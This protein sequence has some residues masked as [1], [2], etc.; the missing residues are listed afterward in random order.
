MYV[1]TS[2][3]FRIQLVHWGNVCVQDRHVDCAPLQGVNFL[4]ADWFKYR[5]N[6]QS[7][8]SYVWHSFAKSVLW[9]SIWDSV[10]LI[11]WDKFY[12]SLVVL[13]S[14]RIGYSQH[15][16]HSRAMLYCMHL[17]GAMH[18]SRD[19]N[20]VTTP[21]ATPHAFSDACRYV[22]LIRYSCNASFFAARPSR[23]PSSA[24]NHRRSHQRS[25]ESIGS[26]FVERT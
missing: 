7:C 8:V 3:R 26:G 12:T 11:L 21:P 24:G 4:P 5:V 20:L 19:I 16:G 18:V 10:P 17:G 6:Q 22:Q 1:A 14:Q 15:H 9:Y 2:T 13:S 23:E 25:E